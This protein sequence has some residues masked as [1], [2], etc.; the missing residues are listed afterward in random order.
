VSAFSAIEIDSHAHRYEPGS[1][2]LDLKLEED[3][4]IENLSLNDEMLK[5]VGW[6]K[7]E[8]NQIRPRLANPSAQMNHKVQ[9]H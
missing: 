5:V 1:L 4:N 6:E 8:E 9:V 7:N 2:I 3:G